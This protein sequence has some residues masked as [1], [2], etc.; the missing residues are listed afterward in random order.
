LDTWRA[1]IIAVAAVLL[2]VIVLGI[3][4]MWLKQKADRDREQNL[5]RQQE[6]VILESLKRNGYKMYGGMAFRADPVKKTF[7]LTG[8][9]ASQTFDVDKVESGRWDEDWRVFVYDNRGER[10]LLDP[11]IYEL[12]LLEVRDEHQRR[13]KEVGFIDPSA[14]DIT[15]D[16]TK[17]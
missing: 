7:S 2:L 6:Q 8:H 5:L 11:A 14:G 12:R 1:V 3:L 4:I 13:M 16:S 9:H 17:S 10:R 15:D